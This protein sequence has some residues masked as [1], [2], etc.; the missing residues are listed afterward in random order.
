[1][2]DARSRQDSGAS[3]M[4]V[5]L[6]EGGSL[7]QLRSGGGWDALARSHGSL[8]FASDAWLQTWSTVLEPQAQ[9]KA[10]TIG[11]PDGPHSILPLASLRR[12]LIRGSRPSLRYVGIAG[13][14]RGAADLLGP[15]GAD[16]AAVDSLIDAAVEVAGHAPLVF[17]SVSASLGTFLAERY[18]GTIVHRRA[19]PQIDL[20]AGYVRSKKLSKNVARRERLMENDGVV[21]QWLHDPDDLIRALPILRDLHQNR[22]SQLGGAGLFDD[23]RMRFLTDLATRVDGDDGM[24]IQLLESPDGPLGA[25]LGFRFGSTF[26]SYKTGWNPSASRFAPG[27]ALHAAAIDWAID[28]G[29]DA[30]YFL[31]GDEPHKTALG[32]SNDAVVTVIVSNGPLGVPL[33]LRERASDRRYRS[34]EAA[35]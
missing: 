23:F 8:Y 13:A 21:R 28:A 2:T 11:T 35:P 31:R 25:L 24:W 32:G 34:K 6:L 30:Y 9:L 19:C 16:P 22:W 18:H 17:D 12:P 15:L 20:A 1:M 4:T 10:L 7:E 5:S 14:G 26:C 27:V 3:D 29:L 33:V